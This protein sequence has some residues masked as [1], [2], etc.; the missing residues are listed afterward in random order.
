MPHAKLMHAGSGFRCEQLEKELQLGLGLDGSAV[1][2][3]PGQ[4]P[5]GWLVQALDQL[6]V[7]APQLSGITLPYAQWCEEPQAQVLFAL[8]NS[9]YLARDTF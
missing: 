1:L 5:Q 4:L 2:H 8:A 3:Y 6:L 7:A 9:D